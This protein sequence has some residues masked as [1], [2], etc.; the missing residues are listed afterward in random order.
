MFYYFQSLNSTFLPCADDNAMVLKQGKLYETIAVWPKIWS[1]SF[2]IRL[3]SSPNNINLY[4][5]S[6]K[7][8]FRFTNDSDSCCNH[9]SNIPG[10]WMKGNKLFVVTSI[11]DN[12][13]QSFTSVDEYVSLSAN[14]YIDDFRL[15]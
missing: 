1:M 7:S 12:A 4:D 6:L 11:N 14:R 3:R 9:G 10:V 15:K 8:I 5:T 13:N 2:K